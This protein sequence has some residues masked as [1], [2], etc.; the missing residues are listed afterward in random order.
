MLRSIQDEKS[1]LQAA[2]QD[3]LTVVE[4]VPTTPVIIA[5]AIRYQIDADVS[6]QDS[7][8]FASVISYLDQ[9]R[10]PPSCFLTKNREDF[11][12]PDMVAELAARN[13]K[14]LYTFRDGLSY[15]QRANP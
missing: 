5:A 8:I 12:D 4:I 13:C 2:I 1:R 9:H 6:P 7:I 3:I 15:L 14:V 11:D 10:D